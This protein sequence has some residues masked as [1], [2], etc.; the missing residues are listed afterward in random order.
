MCKQDWH[1]ASTMAVQ[2]ELQGTLYCVR[3]QLKGNRLWE[4]SCFTANMTSLFNDYIIKNYKIITW[5]IQ[6][7]IIDSTTSFN[8]VKRG[9]LFANNLYV[10][11]KSIWMPV[12]GYSSITQKPFR[13]QVWTCLHWVWCTFNHQLNFSSKIVKE[14]MVYVFLSK[15]EL[16]SLSVRS[17]CFWE[18][19]YTLCI[20]FFTQERNRMSF[21]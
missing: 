6:L 16:S 9:I 2:D 15:M 11:K 10:W 13:L 17:S 21:I 5:Y 1:S 18:D 4:S 7:N 8:R 3:R 14:I 12:V 19:L 20:F